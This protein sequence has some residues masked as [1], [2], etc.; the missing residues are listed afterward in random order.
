VCEPGGRL[1]GDIF[2]N[3]EIKNQHNIFFDTAIGVEKVL[4]GKGSEKD[5]VP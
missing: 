5:L 4:W 2:E 1:R 3:I